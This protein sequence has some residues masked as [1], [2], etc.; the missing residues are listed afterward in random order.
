MQ[1]PIT[2]NVINEPM[3]H[4]TTEDDGFLKSLIDDK[5]K[6]EGYKTVLLKDDMKS[7]ASTVMSHWYNI[8]GTE[9]SNYMARFFDQKWAVL[10][11]SNKGEID[12]DE[13]IKFVRDFIGG[14]I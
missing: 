10:D 5:K 7:V 11:N 9:L 12:Y 4:F 8:Q 1:G 3:D 13:S 6:G 2:L 14:M